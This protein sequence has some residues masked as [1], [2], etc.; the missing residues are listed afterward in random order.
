ME[1]DGMN[2]WR[3]D[4]GKN[5]LWTQNPVQSYVGT[6][7]IWQTSDKSI[8]KEDGKFKGKGR[9]DGSRI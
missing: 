8:E 2:L 5:V 1:K 4:L 3:V 6:L 9:N 7:E